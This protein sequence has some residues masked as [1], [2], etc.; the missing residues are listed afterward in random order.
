VLTAL[1]PASAGQQD[2]TGVGIMAYSKAVL[3]R[4]ATE[5]EKMSQELKTFGGKINVHDVSDAL[6]LSRE[7]GFSIAQYLEYLGWARVTHADPLTLVLTPLGY[8]EIAILRLPKW[9]QWIHRHGTAIIL[10]T[11]TAFISGMF[12]TLAT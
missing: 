11:G 12:Y 1:L 5:A 6:G 9:R 7:D 4:F 3:V 2:S 10:M 8:D